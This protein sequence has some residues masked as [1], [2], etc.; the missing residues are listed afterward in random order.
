MRKNKFLRRPKK[1]LT[2]IFSFFAFVLLLSCSGDNNTESVNL[3]SPDN[4]YSFTF[5]TGNGT[6]PSY[7]ISFEGQEVIASSGLG[8]H[9]ENGTQTVS[10][11]EIESVETDEVNSSWKPVYGEKNSY[12][13]NYKESLIKLKGEGAL[14]NLRVRAY[15]EGVAFRYEFKEAKGTID[16]ELTEFSVSPSATAWSS[17]RAQ[18][19]ISKRKVTELD[20]VVE[21]PLLVQ[22]KDSLF[23]AIGEAALVD[24]A[25]MKL[26]RDLDKSGTLVSE[27]SSKVVLGNTVDKTPWRFVMA[28][29]KPAQL[30]ENNY[31]LLN[32]NEPNKISDTSYIRPGKII[33]ESTLTT[34]G[35]MACVDFAVKHNLQYIEFDAGWYGNEYDDA[36]DATTITIDPKRSKGPL[37]LLNVIKYAKSKNIGV[38]LYV[39]RRALEKQLDE[40]LPLLKSWGVSGIKYGFVNVGPQEWT[41]W[42]HDA[43]RKASEHNLMIDIH[44]EYRPTGYSRTYPNLMTQEG[45]RGDEESPENGEVISTIFTRMIAGA[46]DQT[47]CYFAP[48]VEEKMGSHASQLAKAVCIYSPW[49][50]LYWYD[51]PEGSKPGEEGAGGTKEFIQEVPE[52]AWYDAL[53]TTWDDTHVLDGYPEEYAII[54]RKSNNDW[55]VGALSGST[56]KD[57]SFKLDFLDAGKEYEATLY[58]DD[59]NSDARTKVGI[60]TRKVSSKDSIDHTLLA[61]NGLAVHIRTL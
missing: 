21:R 54:A 45:I 5:N 38:V 58:S 32:I 46:G 10:T 12:P 28:A 9:M 25:R 60:E 57:I 1:H 15:N 41:V 3:T 36:S 48:R 37:D 27:L 50:F 53:P 35:G 23:T 22:L 18:S 33:R 8:F 2:P 47:N 51:R 39:N 52:L 59:P 7:Q 40:V 49:Q 30:L 26:R 29:K 55:F 17:V 43:V 24:Y 14:Y 13:E 6:S 42:L 19:E 31:L 20:T 34:Q 56:G 44:D 11:I 61:N 4:K 16:K